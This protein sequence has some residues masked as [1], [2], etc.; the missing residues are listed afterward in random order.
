MDGR[1]SSDELLDI[2]GDTESR[3]LLVALR[4][5]P[6]TAKELGE[7][8]DLSLPTVYRRLD[9]LCECGLVSSTTEVRDDGTHRRRYD[10][11][12]DET[13]VSLSVEGFRAEVR[14]TPTLSSERTEP[15]AD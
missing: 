9:R 2:L 5:E 1:A 15:G 4:R 11:D 3:A 14:L 12:F 13:V 10:C 7:T 6:R 8:L